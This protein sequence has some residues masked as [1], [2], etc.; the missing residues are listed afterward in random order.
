VRR[1]GSKFNF[2]VPNQVMYGIL[3]F[4]F[5]YLCFVIFVVYKVTA[6]EIAS[7]L[8]SAKNF[9]N[10]QN[11]S[12]D[13]E[14]KLVGILAKM[15]SH[16]GPYKWISKDLFKGPETNLFQPLDQVMARNFEL[17]FVRGDCLTSQPGEVLLLELL[18]R[19]YYTNKQFSKNLVI[20]K[21]LVFSNL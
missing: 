2:C 15:E 19:T 13:S 11:K 18:N 7:T 8:S 3:L 5:F 4:D 16:K 9:L 14:S 6:P 21:L 1:Q 10:F 17:V 12:V 20:I